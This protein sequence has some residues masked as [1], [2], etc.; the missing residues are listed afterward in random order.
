[1]AEASPSPSPE[2]A[3]YGFVLYLSAWVCLAVYLT[4]AYIP[5]SWLHAV[6]L[7]Y[8]PQKYWAVA[9]PIYL[10]VALIFAIFL[11]VALNLTITPAF[12]S[13]YTI[14]DEHAR[15]VR[16]DDRL[17][18]GAIP[19]IEDIPITEVNRVLYGT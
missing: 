1:M 10:T 16:T 7:T 5:D 6:G 19:P 2:R 14:T 17:P 4:W 12:D 9:A 15:S 13:R 18:A 3:A 11:Y 8:W